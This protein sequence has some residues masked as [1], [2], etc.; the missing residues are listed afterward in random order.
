MTFLEEVLANTRLDPA[1]GCRVWL[2]Y[3]WPNGYGE[4]WWQEQR[5]PVHRAVWEL[6]HGNPGALD[7]LHTCDNKPCC[8]PAHLFLGTKLDNNKDRDAKGRTAH[9][10]QQGGHKLAEVQVAE[11]KRLLVAGEQTQ[12]QIACAYRV[13][14][15]TISAIARG[16]TWKHVSW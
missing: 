11:I 9:G 8:E 12:K 1:T 6:I 5:Y 4:V 14:S 16:R 3:V 15:R 13:D 10:E 7:V 2:G